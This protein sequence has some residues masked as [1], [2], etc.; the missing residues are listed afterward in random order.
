MKWPSSGIA[1]RPRRAAR[2]SGQ[3]CQ[4]A[5]QLRRARTSQ[6]RSLFVVGLALRRG[7]RGWR[8]GRPAGAAGGGHRHLAVGELQAKRSAGRDRAGR[9]RRHGRRRRAPARS[10]APARVRRSSCPAGPPESSAA[11]GRA[12]AG[13]RS[14]RA[15]TAPPRRRNAAA[16]RQHL[17][18]SWCRLAAASASAKR[19]RSISCCGVTSPARW[20]GNRSCARRR[21]P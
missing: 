12:A 15:A 8:L 21:M 17:R 19:L 7:R 2:R 18:T 16:S 20:R 4:Q 1:A 14:P 6:Q 9:R 10:R 13:C 5:E 11:S 3:K